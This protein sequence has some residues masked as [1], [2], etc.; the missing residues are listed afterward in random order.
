VDPPNTYT[1]LPDP[2]FVLPTATDTDPAEPELAS[3]LPITT[4]PEP[5]SDAEPDETINEPVDPF[6][7]EVPVITLIAPVSPD[8]VVP[9]ARR[10]APE[11][12]STKEF[13]VRRKRSPDVVF[14]GPALPDCNRMLPPKSLPVPAIICIQPPSKLVPVVLPP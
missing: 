11:S 10:T 13:A 5:P 7:K 14:V 1:S 12:P 8:T 2:L 9:E 4:Y 6:L 3:P